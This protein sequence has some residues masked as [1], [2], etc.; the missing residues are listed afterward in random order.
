MTTDK[1]DAVEIIKEAKSIAQMINDLPETITIEDETT[2]KEIRKKYTEYNEKYGED[3][4][5]INID[6]L[7]AAEE[8]IA[9][10]KYEE[11]H[12]LN[13]ATIDPIDDMAYTRSALTPEPVVRIEDTVLKEGTDYTLEYS[14]NTDVG[15]A[16]IKAT[17]SGD[18]TGTKSIS[19]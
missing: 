12:N 10:I 13:N 1:I 4:L 17:G 11:L 18:Y 14:E 2:I 9:E 3:A 15:T 5:T 6:K 19:V 16:T 7:V 8:T